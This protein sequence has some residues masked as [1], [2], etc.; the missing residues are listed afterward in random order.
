MVH[1]IAATPDIHQEI[2]LKKNNLEVN[3]NSQSIKTSLRTL[4]NGK[5][6]YVFLLLF[7]PSTSTKVDQVGQ[8]YGVISSGCGFNSEASIQLLSSCHCHY[9]KY[10]LKKD[11]HFFS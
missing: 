3:I 2:H 10:V 4:E 11:K 8:R 6:V 1:I 9:N 7:S 5:C